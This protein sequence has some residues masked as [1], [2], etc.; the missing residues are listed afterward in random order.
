MRANRVIQ[1]CLQRKRAFICL[2]LS[3]AVFGHT[4]CLKYSY[5]IHVGQQR[6]VSCFTRIIRIFK[7]QWYHKLKWKSIKTIIILK[8]LATS[9]II[10][11]GCCPWPQLWLSSADVI[12]I[13]PWL[14]VR[15]CMAKDHK[16]LEEKIGGSSMLTLAVLYCC[17]VVCRQLIRY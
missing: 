1:Y 2:A 6:K 7:K 11:K 13:P 9:I 5:A 10:V 4:L 16:F 15:I 12:C 3:S 14:K 8:A 17:A